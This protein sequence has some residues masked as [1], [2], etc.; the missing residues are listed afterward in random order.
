MAW[1]TIIM[2][3]TLVFSW[4]V[5]GVSSHAQGQSQEEIFLLYNDVFDYTELCINRVQKAK[6]ATEF[7]DAVF[8]YCAHIEKIKPGAEK[9]QREFQGIF[10][11]KSNDIKLLNLQVKVT[12]LLGKWSDVVSEK[13]SYFKTI[14]TDTERRRHDAG[15]ARISVV[16]NFMYMLIGSDN[17]VAEKE[18]PVPKSSTQ[19]KILEIFT[20]MVE[21]SDLCRKI[22]DLATTGAEFVSILE[23]YT[24]YME[25]QSL[26][27]LNLYRKNPASFSQ[28]LKSPEVHR[29]LK[30]MISNSE[31]ISPV[32]KRKIEE[33]KSTFT[34][35]DVD[36]LV[37][38]SSR[39]GQVSKN[40]QAINI[41]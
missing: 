4:N 18:E 38:I 5:L 10:K 32:M 23:K 26:L 25:I 9:L 27:C 6:T 17:Y 37:K 22:L 29:K 30:Q 7:L 2:V 3:L 12:D 39:L 20:G 1:K 19:A 33:L 35:Q 16:I 41:E 15:R 8:N 36:N 31:F 34:K 24:E 11:G 40:F 14:Q 13:F 28:A 21:Y